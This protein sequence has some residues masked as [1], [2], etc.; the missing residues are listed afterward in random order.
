MKRFVVSVVMIRNIPTGINTQNKLYAINAENR[1]E[2]I[3]KS[4][5]LAQVDFPEY[6]LHTACSLTIEDNEH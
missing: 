5:P 6:Q 3:G 2:A 4:I 1:D